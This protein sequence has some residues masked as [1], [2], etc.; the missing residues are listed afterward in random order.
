MT[1][2]VRMLVAAV[3]GA[4]ALAPVMHTTTP[5]TAAPRP[6][7]PANVRP[8]LLGDSRQVLIVSAPTWRST[9]ATATLYQRS[10]ST[11]RRVAGPW[12]ARLGKR[13]MSTNHREGSMDT[14]AGSFAITGGMGL[15]AR[16][17]TRMPYS[18]LVPGSCWISDTNHVFYNRLLHTS[19][20]NLPNENLYRIAKAGPYRR[21]L[22]TDY[23]LENPVTGVGSAIFVHIHSYRPNGTT[24]PTGGCVSLSSRQIDRLWALIDPALHPRVVIGT[25][26]WLVTP[27]NG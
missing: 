24:K 25:T 18:R 7:T 19:P 10:G 16:A 11:W 17:G 3:L 22:I 13:G 15:S 8:E 27:T 14:P 12:N 20:C 9:V 1:R 2:L 26:S 6:A 21:F 23:N 4:V 5:A